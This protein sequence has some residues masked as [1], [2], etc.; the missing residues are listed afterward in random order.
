MKYTS[1]EISKRLHE[2]GFDSNSHCG[3]WML[4]T[5][6]HQI[7]WTNEKFSGDKCK[8][9][10]CYDLILYSRQKGTYGNQIIN[11]EPRG[12]GGKTWVNVAYGDKY[13]EY[14]EDLEPQN[15]LAQAI[16][17]ILKERK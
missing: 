4:S 13:R 14:C 11:L 10:D 7:F 9:Y 5:Y 1:Y 15:A 2:L 8:A 16:I 12:F 3:W 6:E 17:K